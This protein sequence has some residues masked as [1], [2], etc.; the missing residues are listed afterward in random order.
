M[1]RQTPVERFVGHQ[2]SRNLS[3]A[4]CCA[5]LVQQRGDPPKLLSPVERHR[6]TQRVP[7]A[8]FEEHAHSPTWEAS[9]FVVHRRVTI[10]GVENAWRNDDSVVV[11]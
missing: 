10:G 9:S 6:I 8:P 3:W 1:V 7:C 11:Q 5:V 2:D 4:S